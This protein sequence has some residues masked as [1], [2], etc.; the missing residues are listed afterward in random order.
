MWLF[1]VKNIVNFVMNWIELLKF[2][3]SLSWKWH[4]AYKYLDGPKLVP[5][6]SVVLFVNTYVVWRDSSI[7]SARISMKLGT[8]IHHVREKCWKVKDQR[9]KACTM[10]NTSF[11][12]TR[13]RPSGV[14]I[15]ITCSRSPILTLSCDLYCVYSFTVTALVVLAVA[16]LLR[17]L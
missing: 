12:S 9:L 4:C 7:L 3:G 14:N 16:L 8:N 2:E 1:S 5:G 17:P 13:W 10:P 6:P 15:N 11:P